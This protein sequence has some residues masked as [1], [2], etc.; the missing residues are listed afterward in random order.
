[1]MKSF[2]PSE[3][4]MVYLGMNIYRINANDL[5]ED[6]IVIFGHLPFTFNGVD[7]YTNEEGV[8]VYVK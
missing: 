8:K 1:M 4:G 6:E 7:C 3:L 5:L 2:N